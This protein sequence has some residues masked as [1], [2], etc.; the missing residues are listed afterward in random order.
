MTHYTFKIPLL[1]Y[2]HNGMQSKGSL[3]IG[4]DPHSPWLGK[5]SR[6]EWMIHQ[7]RYFAEQRQVNNCLSEGR[8]LLL[9]VKDVCDF[10]STY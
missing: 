6:G 1:M 9:R 7:L 10:Q 2:S 3:K 8:G 4:E 5:G